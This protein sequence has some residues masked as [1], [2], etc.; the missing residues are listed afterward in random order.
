MLNPSFY[1]ALFNGDV[2]INVEFIDTLEM[3]FK[4]NFS[5]A[6]R[7]DH[8]KFKISRTI[9]EHPHSSSAWYNQDLSFLTIS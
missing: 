7:D 2:E 5:D 3:A 6:Q 1:H 4:K 9:F 8:K